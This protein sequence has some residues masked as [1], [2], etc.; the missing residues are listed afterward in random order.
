RE[1][2]AFG[3]W[4]TRCGWRGCRWQCGWLWGKL[5]YLL[6]RGRRRWER[7]RSACP[8]QDAALLIHRQPL[9]VDEFFLQHCQLLIVQTELEFQGSIGDAPSAAEHLDDLIQYLIKLHD[10]SSPWVSS[11]PTMAFSLSSP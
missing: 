10:D 5:E 7:V 2:A 4:G 8:D 3:L 6:G 9:G 1:L 11:A